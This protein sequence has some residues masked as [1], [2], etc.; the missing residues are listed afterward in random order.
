[1]DESIELVDE[2]MGLYYLFMMLQV[3]LW[4]TGDLCNVHEEV[5]YEWRVTHSV[6]F[7]CV[8]LE[9]CYEVGEFTQCDLAT[10][11]KGF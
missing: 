5:Y 6:V 2:L 11:D 9:V 10:F 7:R 1:M 3:E 4:F 8:E